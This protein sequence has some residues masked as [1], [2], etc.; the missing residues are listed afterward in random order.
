[1]QKI[2][3]ENAKRKF[4]SKIQIDGLFSLLKVIQ[5]VIIGWFFNSIGY[6]TKGKYVFYEYLVG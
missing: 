1:M 2:T 6:R 3:L 5:H 4:S